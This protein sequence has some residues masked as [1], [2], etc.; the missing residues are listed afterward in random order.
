MNAAAYSK[1]SNKEGVSCSQAQPAS[2]VAMMAEI[3][4]LKHSHLQLSSGFPF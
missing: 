2:L 4:E 1:E 3:W